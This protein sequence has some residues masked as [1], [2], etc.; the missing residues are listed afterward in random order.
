LVFVAVSDIGII[1]KVQIDM[2]PLYFWLQVLL[3]VCLF[4]ETQAMRLHILEGRKEEMNK[5]IFTNGCL[6]S[7]HAALVK[8]LA[9]LLKQNLALFGRFCINNCVDGVLDNF[10][11]LSVEFNLGGR[12]RG[13][14]VVGGGGAG[15]AL[16]LSSMG[17][18]RCPRY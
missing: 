4:A 10:R 15:R 5:V 13:K 16:G 6:G 9:Y 14:A 7:F 18:I 12:K 3:P 17:R 1:Q 11:R 8:Y 2:R